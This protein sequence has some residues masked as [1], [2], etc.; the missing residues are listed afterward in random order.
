MNQANL[1]FL[2]SLNLGHDH[3]TPGVPMQL[4]RSI[5]INAS[6]IWFVPKELIFLDPGKPIDHRV[7]TL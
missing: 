6:L 3:D 1:A 4:L 7:A 2:D 5:T